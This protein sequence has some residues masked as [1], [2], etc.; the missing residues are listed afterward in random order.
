[1]YHGV[2]LLHKSLIFHIIRV[3]LLPFLYIF[4]LLNRDVFNR[5][6]DLMVIS[7]LA[8][9]VLVLDVELQALAVTTMDWPLHRV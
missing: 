8:P 4:D 9:S 7:I 5:L 6:V 3:P 2:P 1:M